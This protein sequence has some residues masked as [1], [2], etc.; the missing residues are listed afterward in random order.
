MGFHWQFGVVQQGSSSP[1]AVSIA[2]N[3]SP[4]NVTIATG[5][6]GTS[7]T[8]AVGAIDYTATPSGGTAPYTYAWVLSEQADPN[9]PPGAFAI[10]TQGTT[11]AAQYD[12]GRIDGSF[13]GGG[14][15]PP[16]PPAGN[17]TYRVVC[18]VSDSGGATPVAAQ[19]DFIVIIA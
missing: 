13:P 7:A 6:P 16:P 4:T 1:L 5:G 11:N 10:N 18:T 8:S 19:D 3:N 15:G 17:A 9:P 2:S 14:P 12:T